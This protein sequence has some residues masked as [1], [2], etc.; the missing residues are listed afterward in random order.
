M[1]DY[2][3][4]SREAHYKRAQNEL[5][6][7]KNQLLKESKYAESRD[8]AAKMALDEVHRASSG[9]M[10]GSGGT[11]FKAFPSVT[12]AGGIANFAGG[13]VDAYQKQSASAKKDARQQKAMD[14]LEAIQKQN[15]FSQQVLQ[16]VKL[17]QAMMDQAP[18]QK[19]LMQARQEGVEG[20]TLND[21]G[22]SFGVEVKPSHDGKSV[23][24]QLPDGKFGEV[25]IGTTLALNKPSDLFQ[26]MLERNV[27]SKQQNDAAATQQFQG[28]MQQKDLQ[29]QQM[30]YENQNL[31]G[32]L[33]QQGAQLQQMG[34]RNADYQKKIN[35]IEASGAGDP[36]ATAEISAEQWQR[37]NRSQDV[38]NAETVSVQEKNKLGMLKQFGDVYSQGAER[39]TKTYGS[40]Q[41]VVK[42]NYDL[43]KQKQ[44]ASDMIKG[45]EQMHN[46]A[47]EHPRFIGGYLMQYYK[48]LEDPQKPFSSA[49]LLAHLKDPRTLAHYGISEMDIKQRR[50]FDLYW[51]NLNRLVMHR[52]KQLQAAGAVGPRPT[53]KTVMMEA[54]TMMS[55]MMGPEGAKARIEEVIPEFH[56]E[57][58]DLDNKINENKQA[59]AA[60]DTFEDNANKEKAAVSSMIGFGVGVPIDDS[61]IR[62]NT[63]N[64]DYI[65]DH[66]QVDKHQNAYTERSDTEPKGAPTEEQFIEQ[67]REMLSNPQGVKK[68]RRPQP[69]Q[70]MQRTDTNLPEESISG[71]GFQTPAPQEAQQ[72][73]E[74]KFQP[75]ADDITK[76]HEFM[77]GVHPDSLRRRNGIELDLKQKREIE[78]YF[79]MYKRWK[80]GEKLYTD[81]VERLYFALERNREVFPHIETMEPREAEPDGWFSKGAPAFAG[82]LPKEEID[83]FFQAIDDAMDSRTAS[84]E[85]GPEAQENYQRAYPTPPSQEGFRM[86]KLLR[87]H[88]EE[89]KNQSR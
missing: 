24:L 48:T 29:L 32:L 41:D 58:A 12:T 6:N 56:Q 46:F 62:R 88:I 34:A 82:I 20:Q 85:L 44:E 77:F 57:M 22:K 4:A 69:P 67:E 78:H 87:D 31:N 1:T 47:T 37:D 80:R 5:A 40:Y 71:G 17:E 30:V 43:Q 35:Q 21:W 38:K 45:M 61:G 81:D 60:W 9:D 54:A 73:V 39:M 26:G 33:Q 86:S 55:H 64:K 52:I 16:A 3:Q 70:V 19:Q 10:K 50:D 8:R 18:S 65:R 25:D 89:R 27:Q 53:E 13:F 66:A 42:A 15:K 7:Q 75:K 83:G 59:K 76:S 11:G 84:P 14:I 74:D 51:K 72:E 28:Q 63:G 2:G 23:F 36:R 68:K 79:D 49:E